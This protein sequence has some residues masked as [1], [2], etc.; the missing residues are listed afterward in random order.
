MLNIGCIGLSDY[1][2][3]IPNPADEIIHSEATDRRLF[4]LYQYFKKGGE[5]AKYMNFQTSIPG[6][7][8]R[9]IS[10]HRWSCRSRLRCALRRTPSCG[11]AAWIL[12]FHTGNLLGMNEDAAAKMRLD[13]HIKPYI[14]QI[15]TLAGEFAAETNYLYMTYHALSH[16]ITPSPMPPMAVLGS[17]PYC[18]GSSVEF[19][20]CAV[21]TLK[22]LEKAGRV[23]PDDQFQ[24]GNS[25]YRL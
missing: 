17:G 2:Q 20:W 25:L 12:R 22:S 10:W 1:P 19:D 14:K 3:T 7:C 23:N 6:F 5:V 9:S 16:D 15:D 8:I 13:H 21:N 18:I 4:A 24:S 11:Q